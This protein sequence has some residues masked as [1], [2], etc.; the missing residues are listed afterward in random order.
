MSERTVLVTGGS[1]GLGLAICRQLLAA[2]YQLVVVSRRTSRALDELVASAGGRV[3]F[4]AADLSSTA[5]LD[6]ICG[7]LRACDTLHGLVNNAAVASAGLHATMAR[8]RMADMV[9]VNLWAPLLLSQAAARAMRRR[10]GR[11]VNVSSVC[12]HASHRGL[13]A[14][15][16]TKTALEGFSRVLA[17]EVGA[18]GVTVNCVAPGFLDTAMTADIPADLRTRIRR[19]VVLPAPPTGADV[20]AAVEFLLSATAG[21]ITAEVIRVDAGAGR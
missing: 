15:T 5:G 18:W 10:G 7:W 3:R 6:E 4:L 13:A 21:A 8:H 17:A 1:R 12:A 19:R 20:A 9:A 11:I 2:G 14:Y 16:A